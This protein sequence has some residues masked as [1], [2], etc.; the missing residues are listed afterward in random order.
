MLA[1]VAELAFLF[2]K[3]CVAI[4]GEGWNAVFSGQPAM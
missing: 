3:V 4:G 1:L 2:I